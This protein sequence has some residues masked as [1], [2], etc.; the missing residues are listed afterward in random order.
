[1]L[2]TGGGWQDQVGGVLGGLKR[3]SSSPS[4]P[5]RV[6]SEP[7]VPSPSA[8]RHLESH[9][10][11]IYT[12]QPRL[13]RTLLQDVRRRWYAA[14]PGV[15]AAVA[16]LKQNA[17]EMAA[18]VL[19]G[20]VAACGACLDIYW[21]QKKV[22]CEAEPASVTRLMGVLRPA[23]LGA[24]LCG[25]GGGG[26]LLLV[27]RRPDSAKEVRKLLRA[28][29]G[30]GDFQGGQAGTVHRLAFHSEDLR[31]RVFQESFVS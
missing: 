17:E 11:L 6:L 7:L 20:D 29:E 3:C 9:L 5:L 26:F 4:L 12:G 27:T 15:T 16:G 31:T 1:M 19:A 25:A 13:A 10:L 23:A 14:E 24:A 8:L 2:T 22:M 28:A 30:A 21:A 18:A